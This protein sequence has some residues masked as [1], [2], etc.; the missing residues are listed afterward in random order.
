MATFIIIIMAAS[1]RQLLSAC[2][3]PFLSLLNLFRNPSS[4]H[5]LL[6]Q[7]MVFMLLKN[8]REMGFLRVQKVTRLWARLVGWIVTGRIDTK[9][10]WFKDLNVFNIHLH[11]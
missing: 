8:T 10:V 1:S 7:E 11:C 6:Y 4:V 3:C 2:V 5:L 9:Y